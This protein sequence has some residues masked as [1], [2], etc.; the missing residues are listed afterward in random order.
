MPGPAPSIVDTRRNQ[1]FPTL[2]PTEIT[3]LRWFGTIRSY[4]AAVH[5]ALGP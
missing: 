4:A 2:E 1:I 5:A 3:R